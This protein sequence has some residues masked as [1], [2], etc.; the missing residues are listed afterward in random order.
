MGMDQIKHVVV[1]MMENRSFDN[2][3]G[4]LYADTGNRPPANLPPQSPPTFAGLEP[5]K[6]SNRLDAPGS[7]PVHATHPPRSWPP[8]CPHPTQVPTPD[9]HEEFEYV[10]QQ[11]FG[12]SPPVPGVPP[13]MSGFL[14]NYATTTAGEGCAGQIMDTFGPKDAG[15]INTL[16]RE[17][18]VC[19]RW[20][21]SVPTQTW[22]NRGF[23]HTGSSDGHVDN[24]GYEPY[25]NRT[26]FNVLSQQGI[27]WEV[28]HDTTYVPSLTHLQFFELWDKTGHFHQFS[29]FKR[30]CSS[31]GE[32]GGEPKL[33]AYT[34]VE[35][36]FVPEPG[37]WWRLF[38]PHYPNDYHPPHDV[39]RG[40]RFLSQVYNAVRSSPYRDD[41][42]LV[43]TFDEHGGCYDHVPPPW[44]S[45][46]PVP[47]AIG[48]KTPF[49]FD[50]FGVRVPTILVSSY[51]NPG[52]VFREEA[53]QT[54]YDHTS[55]LATLRDWLHIR[56]EHFLPSPRIQQ[57]PKLD[58]VLTL[59]PETKRRDW[60][61]LSASPRLL[62]RDRAG[63]NALSPL[64][65]GLLAHMKRK[66]DK[67]GQPL[68]NH[69]AET[70]QNTTTYDHALTYLR[71]HGKL[72]QK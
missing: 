64:Q 46:A 21:A 34:F 52:T 16:A 28:F 43:I 71:K 38:L 18:A 42:L 3:L 9:P 68:A 51:V 30:R 61:A 4:W 26:I 55:I 35:P 49:R 37:E 5:D 69:F 62:W 41:I 6:Y 44:G 63:A 72:G 50:R 66:A 29:E 53:G 67:T 11:L 54:P 19:D 15:V 57:A 39:L 24:E 45:V 32:S 14:Q 22:P 56:A 1:V 20:F 59:T 13:D 10:T 8:A 31:T 25:G 60:P 48:T 23:V 12:R 70:T 17:F 58:P 33:P 7:P 36:R 27:D 2:L 40:E 47:G 65:Q